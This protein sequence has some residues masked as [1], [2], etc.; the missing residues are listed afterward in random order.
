MPNLSTSSSKPY[1]A[2]PRVICM[3]NMPTAPMGCKAM[4]LQYRCYHGQTLVL[5]AM[6]VCQMVHVDADHQLGA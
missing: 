3:G 6:A 1:E 4:L 2:D 5:T